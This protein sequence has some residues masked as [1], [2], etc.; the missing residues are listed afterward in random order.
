MSFQGKKN[1]YLCDHCG[2]AV[3]TQDRDEGV[4][5]FM[6]ACDNCGKMAR[7][8]CYNVPPKL[9]ETTTPAF[10]WYRPDAAELSEVCRTQTRPGMAAATR[11]HVE[12]GGLLK[13]TYVPA[14]SKGG[15]K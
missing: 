12:R 14:T 9:L 1:I 3:V 8:F 11:E 4:T 6:I 13:R 5:P 7:S 10:E 2:R 15:A